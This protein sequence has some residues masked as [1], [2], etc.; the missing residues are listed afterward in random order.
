MKISKFYYINLDKRPDRNTHFIEQCK[1]ENIPDHKIHRF[2]GLDGDTYNFSNLELA[3]FKNSD[4]LRLPNRNRFM[5]NQLS[6]YY[7]LKDIIQHNYPFCI[8]FQDDS[9]LREGFLS[10]LDEIID[11]LPEDSEIINIGFHK[12]CVGKNFIPWNFSE[13]NTNISQPVTNSV[14]R[15]KQG[16]NPC[17]LAYIVTLQG[18]R[19]LVEYFDRTTFLRATDGN[20]NDYLEKR[21]IF[22]GSNNVLVTGNNKFASDIF[23]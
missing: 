16:I 4:V 8:V 6:H 5:G 2:T 3:M 17:S 19:N 14:S 21:D 9:I 11:N 22:Y 13:I 12:F 20:F 10:Y 7:I 18:A 23:I 15:L 1:E